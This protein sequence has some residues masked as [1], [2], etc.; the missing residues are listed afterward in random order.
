MEDFKVQG[1]APFIPAKDFEL[2]KR[3]Y[4]DLGFGVVAAIN[5]AVLL[6]LEGYG[7]WLQDYYIDDWASNCMLCLY[8]EDLNAWHQRLNSMDWKNTYVSPAMILTGP[9]QQ[10]GALMMQVADPSGVL[11]HIRQNA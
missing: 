3:F 11:W 9:H 5:N 2:S 7:F 8:V 10:E 6:Q 1:I 4:L